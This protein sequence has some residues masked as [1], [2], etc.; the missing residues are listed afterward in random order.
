M[1]EAPSQRPPEAPPEPISDLQGRILAEAT[2]LFAERGYS[3]TSIREVVEAAGCTKPALYYHFESKEGLFLACIRTQTDRFTAI[4]E[5]AEQGEGSVRAGMTAGLRV[6][7]DYVRIHPTGIRLLWRAE[8]QPE[9]GQPVFDFDSVRTRHTVLV[10]ERLEQ[11]RAAGE[12]RE[13]V[14]LD[15][16][17][18]A[19][20]GMIDQRLD[21]WARGGDLPED[22][23]ERLL[24]LFFH[25]VAP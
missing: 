2:R 19:L 17:T 11:A 23:P 10:K 12:V 4:I 20:V 3:G 8:M 13:D 7:F 6:F 5:A 16:A 22:L 21:F 1:Q 18:H 25:G 15:D 9:T 14:D 24:G